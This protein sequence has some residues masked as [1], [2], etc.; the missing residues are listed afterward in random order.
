MNFC[1][2][3]S[4]FL[5]GLIAIV[6]AGTLR[7]ENVT[8]GILDHRIK[9][10]I[11]LFKSLMPCGIPNLGI[12]VLAPLKLDHISFNFEQSGLLSLKAELNNLL[13]EDLN[14]FDTV[15]VDLKILQMQLDFSLFFNAI[16][17]TGE[18]KAQGSA[19]GLIPFNRGGK[20]AFNLNGL[21]LDGSIK[22][23]LDGD[24][25]LLKELKQRPT[26]MSVN[27]KF[28]GAF[29]LPMNTFIFN[30][31]VETA[32]PKF[33]RDNEELVSSFLE[34]MIKPQMNKILQDYTLKNLTDLLG[35]STSSALP[36]SC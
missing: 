4:V 3:L 24:K 18:Y 22:V 28:E 16:K 1:T 34:D 32:L 13:V 26:V 11:E 5:L 25:I 15:N 8:K 27:S 21:T 30:K 14:K 33:L 31:I 23:K 6:S 36:G 19:I 20:V 7:S 10:L 29:L 2:A 12:P 35:N 9:E 17:V